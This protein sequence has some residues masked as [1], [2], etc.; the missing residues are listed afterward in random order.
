MTT[1][2]TSVAV[3][4]L[5]A[6]LQSVHN[7]MNATIGDCP[8]EALTT[9]FPDATIGAIGGIYAAAAGIARVLFFLFLV[10]FLVSLIAGGIVINPQP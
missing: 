10:L 9:T 6:Q 7:T 8:P 1:S 3:S 5:R 2:Q 4:L